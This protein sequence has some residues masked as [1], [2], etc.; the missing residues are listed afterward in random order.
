MTP[1]E[2]H[3]RLLNPH[4]YPSPPGT[5]EL[6]ETHAS[7]IYLTEKKVYKIKKPVNLGFLDFSTLEQ[8]HH[9][10]LQEVLL[11]RRFAPDTYIG[12]V[13]IRLH[14][15]ELLIDGKEGEIVEYAIE[16]RR[17]PEER[18][19]DRLVEENASCL[20]EEAV[21][22]GTAL[23]QMHKD[24]QI[25]RGEIEDA[26]TVVQRNWEENFNQTQ[27]Y[28]GVTIS[29]EALKLLRE[30]MHL[31]IA[32]LGRQIQ[33]REAAGQVRD[34]HGDLHADHICLTDPICIYDCIEFNRRFRV[35]DIL[36]DLA[37]L[38]MDLDKRGR[39]DLARIIE[40]TWSTLLGEEI[41]PA[42]LRF[43]EIYRAFVRGKVNSFLVDDPELPKKEREAA[44]VRARE[45]FD[46]AIGYLV[47]PT[48][49]ITCGAMGVGKTTLSRALSL[50]V[51]GTH[52]RSDIVRKELLGLDPHQHRPEHFGEGLYDPTC[53]RQTYDHLL[54]LTRSELGAGHSVIVDAAF[55][56]RA[57][58][59][60]FQQLATD[61]GTVFVLL[62]LHCDEELLRQRLAQRWQ[63]R[64]DLS[65]G[66][67]E[68]LQQHLR[69]FT[70]PT[71]DENA[72]SIDSGKEGYDNIQQILVNILKNY[73][74]TEEVC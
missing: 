66:R 48:L 47:P 51:R 32:R 16:M 62:D 15:G 38:L 34:G 23:A 70:R 58:R 20:S 8:R 36:A 72:M 25:C 11:N 56:D 54:K 26:I 24:C 10:C 2:L 43:Y 30:R 4:V 60:R 9:F 57:E 33:E 27:H 65:D 50:A 17:L 46:L 55:A 21:R 28:A 64:L 29:R 19:L 14:H 22:L 18:M 6:R 1:E 49:F 71:A 74:I 41:D 35:G 69:S 37:F 40:K 3:Q 5:I 53:S 42:L 59:L 68:L 63:E 67:P 45:Y 31:G 61:F 52:L 73:N 12:V 44:A 39:Q 13:P 7:C